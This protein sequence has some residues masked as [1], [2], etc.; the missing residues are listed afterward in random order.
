MPMVL[1][2]F[3]GLLAA[4][5]L[6]QVFTGRQLVKPSAS[7]RSTYQLRRESAAATVAMT[8]VALAAMHV[9]WGLLLV[10]LGFAWLVLVRKRAAG[11]ARKPAPE[12]R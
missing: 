2:C 8:G 7:K 9:L 3:A 4:V 12:S 5:N 11:L 6:V 10:V 1:A